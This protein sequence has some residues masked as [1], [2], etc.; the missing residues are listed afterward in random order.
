MTTIATVPVHPAKAGRG[1]ATQYYVANQAE[2]EFALDEPGDID[3]A[4]LNED[5]DHVDR[6]GQRAERRHERR[7]EQRAD[8]AA[9]MGEEKQRQ[10]EHQGRG[11]AGVVVARQ[12]DKEND[13]GHHDDFGKS[14]AH[15]RAVCEQNL[16]RPCNGIMLKPGQQ[17]AERE[18]VEA[19]DEAEIIGHIHMMRGEAEQEQRRGD[20]GGDKPYPGA[21]AGDEDHA[22]KQETGKKPGR[23]APAWRVP[24][25]PIL[26][27]D[28]LQQKEIGSQAPEIEA[29]G[30]GS[31]PRAMQ[32]RQHLPQQLEGG[33][34]GKHYQMR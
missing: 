5:V 22:G 18:A 33:K 2:A 26:K 29:A 32:L 4:R 30:E 13:D 9:F 23:N 11:N 25:Q 28:T 19:A 31:C 17:G 15:P 14:P 6:I 27:A 1:L 21:R 7:P 24:R 12:R 34:G 3:Q 10:G 20:G 8:P 16:S